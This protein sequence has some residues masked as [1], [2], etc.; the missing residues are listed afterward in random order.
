MTYLGDQALSKFFSFFAQQVEKLIWVHD[1]SM[2]CHQNVVGWGPQRDPHSQSQHHKLTQGDGNDTESVPNSRN[3]RLSDSE[4]VTDSKGW[5]EIVGVIGGRGRLGMP[6]EGKENLATH[7][8][9]IR[10]GEKPSNR[11]EKQGI[12]G[13]KGNR[14]QGSKE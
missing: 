9:R 3:G 2:V 7:G 11:W 10:N 1:G 12:K 4:S 13:E 5:R 8:G 6:Y 14:L